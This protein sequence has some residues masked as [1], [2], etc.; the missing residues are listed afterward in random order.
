M[1]ANKNLVNNG[2]EQYLKNRYE[3]VA[4]IEAVMCNPNGNPNMANRPRFDMMT[5]NGII[6]DVALKSRIRKYIQLAYG[7]QLDYDI[8][9]K[10]CANMNKSIYEGFANTGHEKAK[11]ITDKTEAM[12]DANDYIKRRYWDARAFGAVLSTGRNAGQI[13]GAVQ[14]AMAKSVDPIEVVTSTITRK[15]FTA[16]CGDS[17]SLEDYEKAEEN[18]DPDTKRTMGT[19]SYINYGLYVVKISVSANVA[20][21]NHFTEEDFK[22]LLEGVMQMYNVDASSSKMGMSVLSPVVV[23]KHVGL[24]TGTDWQNEN[25]ALLG[26]TSA[27][28]LFN[29]V[30]VQKKDGIEYPRSYE[31]YDITLDLS[32]LPRGVECGVKRDFYEDIDWLNDIH[33]KID[34]FDA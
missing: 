9:I 14:I 16:N 24:K 30:K 32:R 18:M 7:D 27:N 23:F 19:K 3:V 6:T 5:N 26:C 11:D 4:L 20:K 10:D 31:D 17:W 15:C 25:E 33:E 28:R 1:N 29:L 21:K 12:N 34:L 22:R 8:L 2:Q 13:R